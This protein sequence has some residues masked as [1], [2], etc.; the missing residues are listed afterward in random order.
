DYN[1][2][3]RDIN[4][5]FS[6]GE[7]KKSEVLQMLVLTPKVVIL[8]EFDSGLD[9]NSVGAVS[10]AISQFKNKKRIIILI[11]HYKR[12]FDFI[13]VDRVYIIKNGKI[14][15]EGNPEIIES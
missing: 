14:I 10:E 7:K 8:D 4:D 5:G 12:I 3:K 13:K 15:K 11:T 2:L 6:G 1:L 9:A